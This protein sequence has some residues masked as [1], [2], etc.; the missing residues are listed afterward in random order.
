[1]ITEFNSGPRGLL[2][3][4]R[5]KVRL[6]NRGIQLD[7]VRSTS[8]V[9][10]SF[11][12]TGLRLLPIVALPLPDITNS[13]DVPKTPLV[14]EVGIAVAVGMVAPELILRPPTP[15]IRPLDVVA[16]LPPLAI[17]EPVL[18]E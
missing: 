5:D 4:N 18:V 3:T 1:M 2:R 10:K 11:I 12:G 14:P 6:H 9:A 8:H 16:G 17:V 15:P 7:G 13:P